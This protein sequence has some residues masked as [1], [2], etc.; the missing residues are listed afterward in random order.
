MKIQLAIDRVPLEKA[1]A[2]ARAC[3]PFVEIVEVGTSLIKDFGISCVSA[4]RQAC[5]GTAVLA[6]IKTID[7]GEYEFRAAYRGGADIATVMGAA[8]PATVEA[9]RKV[10]NE[11]GRDYMIDLLE[12]SP[13][14]LRELRQFSDAIFCVHLPADKKGEGLSQLIERACGELRGAERLAVAGGVTLEALGQIK[15]A[16][17][18]IAIVGG[19]IARAA[20]PAA[21]AREFGRLAKL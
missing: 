12:V 11:A 5:P 21:A 8:S 2:I 6:D 16:G 18:E 20:E 19:A 14:K 3:G 9:C 1:V 10:A 15:A 13:P 4:V 17:F 7:E